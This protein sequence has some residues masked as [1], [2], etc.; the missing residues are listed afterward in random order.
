[1]LRFVAL[2]VLLVKLSMEQHSLRSRL[3]IIYRVRIVVRYN[4]SKYV[5]QDVRTAEYN[6]IEY[7]PR[8]TVGITQSKVITA[9]LAVYAFWVSPEKD[10]TMSPSTKKTTLGWNGVISQV[11][12]PIY[13]TTRLYIVTACSWLNLDEQWVV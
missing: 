5:R 6:I 4:V 8:A 11:D 12:K 2:N 1:M 7:M 13:L 3:K 10:G 9:F